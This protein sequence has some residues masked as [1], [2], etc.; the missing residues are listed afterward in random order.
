MVFS[1]GILMEEI[2]IS[3]F[4]ATCLSVIQQVVKTKRPVRVT[5]FGVPVAEIVP[6]SVTKRPANWLGSRAGTGEIL[7]DIIEPACDP[8]DWDVLR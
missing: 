4:K 5:R 1:D 3:K 6:P 8:G 2:A 7:G